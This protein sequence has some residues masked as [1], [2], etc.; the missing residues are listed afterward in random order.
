[1]TPQW[2]D[3]T[4]SPPRRSHGFPQPLD[5]QSRSSIRSRPGVG[6][7]RNDS[8][9]Y[10]CHRI[11]PNRFGSGIDGPGSRICSRVGSQRLGVLPR[12]CC[13]GEHAIMPLV[14]RVRVDSGSGGDGTD[15]RDSCAR[16]HASNSTT[17]LRETYAGQQSQQ[18]P[19]NEHFFHTCSSCSSNVV[20]GQLRGTHNCD[21]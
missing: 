8:V 6:I 16:P 5:A 4:A 11:W 19:T 17:A 14:D 1:M 18:H 13:V 15:V 21:G 3:V 20:R 2:A 7:R 9:G 10:R 12:G